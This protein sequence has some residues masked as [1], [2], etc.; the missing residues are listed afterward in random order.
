[1]LTASSLLAKFLNACTLPLVVLYPK[2]AGEVNRETAALS[3]KRRGASNR[4]VRWLSES[5]ETTCGRRLGT[6]GFC[7][8]W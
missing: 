4:T 2:I 1:M 5:G 6:R 3:R 8:G 7:G